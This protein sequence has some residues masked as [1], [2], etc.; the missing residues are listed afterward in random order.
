MLCVLRQTKELQRVSPAVVHGRLQSV[1]LEGYPGHLWRACG[2]TDDG[3]LDVVARR[4]VAKGDTPRFIV[5]AVSPIEEGCNE[6][7]VPSPEQV[8]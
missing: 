5:E 8:L 6:L 7:R 4:G 1:P 3:E 2:G